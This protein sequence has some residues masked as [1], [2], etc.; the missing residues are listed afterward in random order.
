MKKALDSEGIAHRFELF[1]G[2]MLVSGENPEKIAAVLSRVFG[3][4]D[5]SVCFRTTNRLDDLSAAA[6]RTAK[7]KLRPGTS[8][9]IRAKRQGVAAYT[10]Q[11]MG[12]VIG[13]AVAE[14]FNLHIFKLAKTFLEHVKSFERDVQCFRQ[15]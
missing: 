1:R 8:F 5:V 3:V 9:A 4:V 11:Q 7:G 12:E 14:V 15:I 6:V 13:R 2:R 10:S